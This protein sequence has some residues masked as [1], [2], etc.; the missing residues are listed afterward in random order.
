MDLEFKNAFPKNPKRTATMATFAQRPRNHF[1]I[2]L[3]VA[4]FFSH[5]AP[6]A[7]LEQ[8]ISR[9]NPAFN[10]GSARLVIGR[11]GMVYLCSGGNSSFVLR[12]TPDGKD[13]V[14]GPIV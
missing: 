2:A 8:I 11:D 3:L 13:K 7:M 10:A 12:L 9:E 1:L 14:G 6:G 4:G 5:L